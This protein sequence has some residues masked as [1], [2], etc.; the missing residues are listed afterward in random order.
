MSLPSLSDRDRVADV[1]KSLNR[2]KQ[3]LVGGNIT[4]AAT[5]LRQFR[6]S[7]VGWTV[8]QLQCDLLELRVTALS[9]SKQLVAL[10][11]KL[12]S[13][14][15]GKQNEDPYLCGAAEL[16]RKY[17]G[18]QDALLW[19][20]KTV[21]IIDLP[22]PQRGRTAAVYLRLLREVGRLD[23]ART[24]A[25][26][27]LSRSPL[28][29][30]QSF[31]QECFCTLRGQRAERRA[32]LEERIQALA[33][34]LSQPDQI[35]LWNAASTSR[36]LVAST[37]AVATATS[38]DS[39]RALKS[40]VALNRL[41]ASLN[42]REQGYADAA[43]YLAQALDASLRLRGE[44]LE[45]LEL[46][47][48]QF[49]L[50]QMAGKIDQSDAAWL[51]QLRAVAAQINR[52]SYLEHRLANVWRSTGN[53]KLAYDQYARVANQYRTDQYGI[54]SAC[55]LA[56]ASE[57]AENLI[58]AFNRYTAIAAM[59][60]TP[61]SVTVFCLVGAHRCATRRNDA[62]LQETIFQSLRNLRVDGKTLRLG[63]SAVRSLR[64]ASLGEAADDMLDQCLQVY[65]V[66]QKNSGWTYQNYL[67][68]THL[69]SR[70]LYEAHRYEDAVQLINS[71][72]ASYWNNEAIAWRDLAGCLC[73]ACASLLALGQPGPAIE[74]AG[75]GAAPRSN[76]PAQSAQVDLALADVYEQSQGWSAAKTVY[77]RIIT[78]APTSTAAMRAR[79]QLA[80]RA[81]R[82]GRIAEARQWAMAMLIDGRRGSKERDLQRTYWSAY[83]LAAS[84]QGPSL[85][86]DDFVYPS[87]PT[88]EAMRRRG[89][90]RL[91]DRLET[92]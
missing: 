67:Y 92:P 28:H 81:W 73:Y 64:E 33:V 38:T 1:L 62:G 70:R 82:Q 30:H 22:R 9:D 12:H 86:G 78:S 23:E 37:A 80:R 26:R 69:L 13:R 31:W 58:D 24:M 83:S 76:R 16:I 71:I 45:T 6:D 46:R 74:V 65:N 44:C 14:H 35:R 32:G 72:D 34:Q 51:A 75:Y 87:V 79:W 19:L 39:T 91:A 25:D 47:L 54:R 53:Y 55:L 84:K 63:L 4:E 61:L 77:N 27:M 17:I 7:P 52:A 57:E 66:A 18:A 5:D 10:A 11:T 48:Q 15:Q 60:Q 85:P 42:A 41:Q 2:A 29:P 20:E 21:A 49:Q 8:R 36:I 50:L 3:A 90:L 43:S 56:A 68:Y 59:P 40:A 88:L 89:E